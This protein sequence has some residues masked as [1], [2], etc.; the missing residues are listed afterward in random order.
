MGGCMQDI[1]MIKLGLEVFDTSSGK[2]TFMVPTESL[3]PAGQ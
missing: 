2:T 1:K 3:L